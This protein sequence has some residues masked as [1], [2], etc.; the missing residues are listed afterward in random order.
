[1]GRTLLQSTSLVL[2]LPLSTALGQMS[3]R[4]TVLT[5]TKSTV[6]SFDSTS[7]LRKG[8][9]A[10]EVWIRFDQDPRDSVS[11]GPAKKAYDYSLVRYQIDC[12]NAR[13]GSL[14][15]AYYDSA[16][17]IVHVTE[18]S[19][20][21]WALVLPESLNEDF[22]RSFCRSFE[23][24]TSSTTVWLVKDTLVG[25]RLTTPHISVVEDDV[26]SIESAVR[27]THSFRIDTTGL[28]PGQ[29]NAVGMMNRLP[30]RVISQRGDLYI[31]VGLLPG[32]YAVTCAEH[33]GNAREHLTVSVR[34]KSLL[35]KDR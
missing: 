8:G 18:V 33:K 26:I 5:T 4:W 20:V 25:S 21:K 34:A 19:E 12:A 16:G 17:N 22:V 14:G 9:R 35:P 11:V 32:T 2:L 29:K 28:S 27:G 6:V 31:I 23:N 15:S 30:T 24:G 7:V 13:Q 10:Y 1:M 3:S